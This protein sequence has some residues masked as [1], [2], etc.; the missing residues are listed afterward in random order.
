[1]LLKKLFLSICIIC[2]SLFSIALC[3]FSF[4]K[5]SD[6]KPV[7]NISAQQKSEV[8]QPDLWC[9]T[10]QLVWNEFSD[11]MLKGKSVQFEGG[12]P[13]L[14]DEL[15]QKV[16]TKD[17]LSNNSYYLADGKITKK[18]KEKIEKDIKN[19]FNEKSDILDKINWN[20][21]NSYLFYAMLKK[22]FTFLKEFNNLD[23]DFFNAQTD[24]KVKYFGLKKSKK[25]RSNDSVKV[26]FYNN[27]DEY[28]VKLLTKENENVILFRTDKND[29]FTNQYN[30][31]KAN[32]KRDSFKKSDEL[33]VPYINVDKLISYDELCGKKIKGTGF[34]ITQALQTIKFKM[35]NKGGSLKS[36][37]A[38]AVM[39]TALAP[40]VEYPRFF[41]YDK[42]FV[43]FLTEEGKDLPY[44]AMYVNDTSYLV[45]DTNEKDNK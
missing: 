38:I 41:N 8:K 6:V 1:M 13:P 4:S 2:F 15:N 28:A 36:E 20:A 11:K 33:K 10:F 21:K 3:G 12:N 40:D 18:L 39:K 24:S 16:Y 5:N 30:Y 25:N 27:P 22:N 35:D 26:L 17:I 7:N 34:V 44:F 23:S 37:A 45:K 19:K 31:I 43:L 32:I 14:A 9:V 42:P 29:T